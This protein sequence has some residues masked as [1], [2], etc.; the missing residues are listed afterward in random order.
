MKCANFLA[1][2]GTSDV[3]SVGRVGIIL[4]GFDMQFMLD[5]VTIVEGGVL[6]L[7]RLTLTLH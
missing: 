4:D 2:S 3:R 7:R 6:Y 1:L 5:N